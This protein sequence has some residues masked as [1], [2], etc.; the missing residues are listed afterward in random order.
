MSARRGVAGRDCLIYLLPMPSF[1][2]FFDS[3]PLSPASPSLFFFHF[4]P[5][6]RGARD[7]ASR[8]FTA[9]KRARNIHIRL[10]LLKRSQLSRSEKVGKA[11][12]NRIRNRPS[13]QE[14]TVNLVVEQ[15][16]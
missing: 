9:G 14:F 11:G 2:S 13:R 10:T 5:L 16:K 15:L 6:C 4:M 7:D 8:A 12:E 3:P 1:S